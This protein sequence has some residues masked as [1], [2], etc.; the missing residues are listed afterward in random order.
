M[1]NPPKSQKPR[2]VP[3]NKAL[4]QLR[5]TLGPKHPKSYAKTL[6]PKPKEQNATL[7]KLESIEPMGTRVLFFSLS[8]FRLGDQ[9]LHLT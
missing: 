4:F 5:K 2:R 7:E 8:S 6:D 1:L 9:G 3:Q